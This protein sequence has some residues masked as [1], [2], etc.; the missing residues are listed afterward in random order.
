MESLAFVCPVPCG[1][2]GL[3]RRQAVVDSGVSTR[4]SRGFTLVR[5]RRVRAASVTLCQVTGVS[6]S[7]DSAGPDVTVVESVPE[8]LQ[9]AQAGDLDRL[10]AL[11]EAGSSPSEADENGWSALMWAARSG[12]ADA[13]D[14]LIGKGADVGAE[15]KFK[16]TAL[17]HAAHWGFPDI[18]TTL[19]DTLAEQMD[20]PEEELVDVRNQF[21]WTPLHWAGKAGMAAAGSVLLQRGADVNAKNLFGNT[22][23]HEAINSGDMDVINV[24]L[25]AIAKVDRALVNEQ[26]GEGETPIVSAAYLGSE[27][28]VKLLLESGADVTVPDSKGFTPLHR[29]SRGGHAEVVEILLENETAKSEIDLDAAT[30]DDQVTALHEAARWG[31]V[32]TIE[33][34]M[35]AGADSSRQNVSGESPL[36]SAVMWGRDWGSSDCAELLLENGADLYLKDF[37]GKTPIDVAADGLDPEDLE[38]SE[39]YELL[40]SAKA[41]LVT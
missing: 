12:H 23:L 22:P 11:I 18:V 17:H 25:N 24:I 30:L 19:L 26:N 7:G 38:D 8:M 10:G 13:V 6:G 5:K 2:C 20:A 36:H 39:V 37:S 3:G 4:A 34:L 21:G 9:A 14:F 29:A 32:D 35:K 1:P 28:V 16:S 15:N 41:S 31:H 40:Q 27:E 33:I